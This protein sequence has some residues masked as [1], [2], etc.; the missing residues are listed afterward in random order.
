M[1][2]VCLFRWMKL[3]YAC[4]T[5]DCLFWKIA[6]HYSWRLCSIKQILENIL[7][8]L[9]C[10]FSSCVSFPLNKNIAVLPKRQTGW[11]W[12]RMLLFKDKNGFYLCLNSSQIDEILEDNS[13]SFEV[14]HWYL[15]AEIFNWFIKYVR[16]CISKNKMQ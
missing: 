5:T 6:Y 9:L 8:A 2:F 3:I 4:L 11:L 14:F 1:L 16:D 7:H 15:V 10:I 12:Y 13:I